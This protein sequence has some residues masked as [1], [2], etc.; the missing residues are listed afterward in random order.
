MQRQMG[1]FISVERFQELTAP[2]QATMTCW[3]DEDA[4]AACRTTL[5][6]LS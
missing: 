3:R 2:T 1:G 4:L 6:D 5:R